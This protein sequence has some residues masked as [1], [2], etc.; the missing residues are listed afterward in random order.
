VSP[1]CRSPTLG[2]SELRL[3]SQ[4][5]AC[6]DCLVIV[7]VLGLDDLGALLSLAEETSALI[8]IILVVV[9]DLLGAFLVG[10]GGGGALLALG[11]GLG[12]GG[13]A[14]VDAGQ[15]RLKWL[16]KIETH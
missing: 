4:G 14:C 1:R 7:R 16:S 6:S 11:S 12:L 5:Q 13:S 2:A 8:L 9:I 3:Q 15:M 10:S